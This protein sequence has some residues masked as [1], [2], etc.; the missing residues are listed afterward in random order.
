M[1]FA[2]IALCAFLTACEGVPKLPEKVL[3]PVST[4]C[5]TEVI[6]QPAFVTDKELRDASEYNFVIQLAKDRLER[7]Q[8]IGELEG[9]IQGCR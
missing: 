1:R 6:Q 2:A 7:R 3:V 5:I 8:Y 9:Q 4:P